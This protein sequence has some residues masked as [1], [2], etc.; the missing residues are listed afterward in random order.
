MYN[1][2]ATVGKKSFWG[3]WQMQFDCILLLC[4]SQRQ[5]ILPRNLN[6]QLHVKYNMGIKMLVS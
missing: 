6:I 3:L 2:E 1:R 4:Q 5:K